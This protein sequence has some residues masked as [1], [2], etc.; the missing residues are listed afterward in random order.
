MI[1]WRPTR[2]SRANTLKTCPF[3]YRGLECKSRK[4]RNTWSNRQIGPWST[5]WSKA[6]ASRVLPRG[7]TGGGETRWWRNRMGRLLSPPQIHK[8]NIWTPSKFNKTTS[9]CRQRTSGTQKSSTFSSKGGRK[10][11]KR[12]KNRDKRGRD[13]APSWEGSLQKRE[14]SKHQETSLPN[15]CWALEAQRAT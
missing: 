2:P 10:K 12:Q 14:V 6:K 5:E 7:H 8:K 4:S 9:E 1:L 15:L 11:Y 13:G 3:C